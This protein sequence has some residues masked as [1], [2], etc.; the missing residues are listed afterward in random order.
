MSL[1]VTVKDEQTGES[2]EKRVRD[3]GFVL[4]TCDPCYLA[5]TNAFKNGTTV[6]TVKIDRDQD[7][8]S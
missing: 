2:Q 3:G 6:L 5:H 4:I 8:P 7:V 1:I